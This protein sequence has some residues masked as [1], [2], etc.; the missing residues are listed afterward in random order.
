MQGEPAMRNR[1]AT[2]S[3]ASIF[4]VVS[5]ANRGLFVRIKFGMDFGDHQLEPLAHRGID[6]RGGN[7]GQFGKGAR[8]RQAW[9]SQV[10][11]TR[12]PQPF[13]IPKCPNRKKRENEN[14]SARKES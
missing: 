3:P 13:H 5:L 6:H 1:K 11:S 12:S 2:Q 14:S 8:R 4:V 10:W 9:L 7:A